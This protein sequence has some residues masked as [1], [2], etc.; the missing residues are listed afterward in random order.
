MRGEITAEV[1]PISTGRPT[2]DSNIQH[3]GVQRAGAPD[4][5]FVSVRSLL[6]NS[7]GTSRSRPS[8]PVNPSTNP[9]NVFSQNHTYHFNTDHTD[10]TVKMGI[11]VPEKNLGVFSKTKKKTIEVIKEL[12]K[13]LKKINEIKPEKKDASV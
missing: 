2:I 4:E 7:S 9:V 8:V 3:T 1:S 10:R 5:R 13:T 12:E 6:Q 11:D